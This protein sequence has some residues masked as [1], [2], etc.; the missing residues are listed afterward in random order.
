MKKYFLYTMTAAFIFAA[1]FT[2]CETDKVEVPTYTVRFDSKGGT[3][4]PQEQTVKEDGKVIKPADPTRDNYTFTGWAKADNETAALWNF[5]TETV[6]G[7]ITLFARWAINTHAVTFDSDGGSAVTAQN[8]AHGSPATKPANPTRNGYEFDGW[9]SGETEW[10]FANAITAPITLKAKW[11]IVYNVIFDSDGGS[12]IPP[13]TVRN[14]NKV[15][16]PTDPTKTIGS[17]LYLGTITGNYTFIGWYNGETLWNFESNTVTAPTTLKARWSLTGNAKRIESVLSNDV[18]AAVTYVNANSNSGEEYTLLLGTDVTV[19]EQTLNA[20]NAKF[21][22]IGLGEVRTISE[23]PS[24]RTQSSLF[25]INGNNVTSLTLGKNITLKRGQGGLIGLTTH[26][27]VYVQR[28]SLTMSDGSKITE[29]RGYAVEVSGI[30]AVF[31]M[32]GGEISE[33]TYGV[34]VKNGSTFEVS[35]G[36]ITETVYTDRDRG[37]VF[38]GHDCIFRLSG[39][40][41]IGTLV[42]SAANNTTMRSLVTINGNYSGTV[43]SLNLYGNYSNASIVATWWTNVSVIVNGTASVINMFNNGLGNFRGTLNSSSPISATHVL[44][45]TGILVLKEN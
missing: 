39:N 12:E 35:G 20:A 33:N 17:G 15:T 27:L 16:K 42:L 38:I 13:Q 8:V 7:D 29:S 1:V 22:I 11:A 25:T 4:T 24:T 43:T 19:G 34:S 28:G 45:S 40:N 10:N 21:T 3:P 41:R 44:N 36:I 30:N 6:S 2:S 14:G 32:E 26:Y 9:F 23:N 31:K 18:A 37:D 5:E